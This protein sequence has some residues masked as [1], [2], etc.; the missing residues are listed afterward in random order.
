MLFRSPS[1]HFFQC[2]LDDIVEEYGDSVEINEKIGI[3][4]KMVK[5]LMGEM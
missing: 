1:G 5:N 4:M 3:L 2:A